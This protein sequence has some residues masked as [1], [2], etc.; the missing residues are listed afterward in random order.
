MIESAN[1][2][3]KQTMNTI[4]HI[5]PNAQFDGEPDGSPGRPYKAVED[6]P[7]V[8][9]DDNEGTMQIPAGIG[10]AFPSG[11]DVPDE[12]DV[13]PSTSAVVP[14]IDVVP[15]V[16][17]AAIL[18]RVSTARQE[19][20]RQINE[21]RAAAGEKGWRVVSVE[22]EVISGASE[23]EARVK[24]DKILGLARSGAITKVMV[25]EISRLS[26]RNSVVHWFVEEISKVGVS[27]YWHSQRIETLL[28][29][30]K[31][32]PAAM[33]MLAL[34]AEMARSERETLVE[35]IRSG[36]EE[37]RRQGKHVGRPEGSKLTDEQLM[38]KYPKVV[39]RIRDG[40]TRRDCAAAC[41]VSPSLVGRVVKVMVRKGLYKIP[42]GRR[43]GILKKKEKVG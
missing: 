42:E 15:G 34:L 27:L 23:K 33:L 41:G 25:H 18:V 39:A 12:S 5:D 35:R 30:G 10:F 17:R 2:K 26:R 37:A 20:D 16:E 8:F 11:G 14:E 24:L 43:G 36:M 4:Y 28:P 19:T 21:L 31:A 3:P 32:N 9:H 40:L 22:E 38:A 6:V 29:G 7:G 1:H 13:A